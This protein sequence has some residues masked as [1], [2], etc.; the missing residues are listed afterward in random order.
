MRCRAFLLLLDNSSAFELKIIDADLVKQ[1]TFE[2]L[3]QKS[4]EPVLI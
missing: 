1:D 2:E 4:T 3:H